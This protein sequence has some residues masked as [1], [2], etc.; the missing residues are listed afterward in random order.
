MLVIRELGQSPLELLS[1][2]I[3]GVVVHSL[4]SVFKSSKQQVDLAQVSA[5]S[6]SGSVPSVAGRPVEHLPAPE[7]DDHSML[8]NSLRNSGRRVLENFDLIV[9]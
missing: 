6:A 4:G 5:K 2:Q 8:G 1:I 7:L 3:Q 9:G